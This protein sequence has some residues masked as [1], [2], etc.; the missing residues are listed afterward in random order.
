MRSSINLISESIDVAVFTGVDSDGVRS[1]EG[2]NRAGRW[3]LA[4]ALYV[5]IF[6]STGR[7]LCGGVDKTSWSEI[8]VD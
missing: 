3:P 5:V 7:I 1:G 2:E 8:V 4:A 6:N